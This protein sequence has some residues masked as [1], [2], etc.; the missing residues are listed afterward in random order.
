VRLCA[1]SCA[2]TP[3]I[4][5]HFAEGLKDHGIVELAEIGTAVSREGNRPGICFVTPHRVRAPDRG[6]CVRTFD[7]LAGA[8]PPPSTGVNGNAT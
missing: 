6:G 7:R 2:R 5:R 4:I 8:T 1:A 3:E